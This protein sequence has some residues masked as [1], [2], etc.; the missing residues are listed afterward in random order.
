M[1]HLETLPPNTNRPPLVEHGVRVWLRRT[2]AVCKVRIEGPA[3][4]EW[5]RRHL[6]AGFACSEPQ[7]V[8]GTPYHTF[9][10]ALGISTTFARLQ[11][12]IE[13]LP[14]ATLMLDPA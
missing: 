13:E 3:A 6:P 10:I 5:L 14:G 11:R 7:P 12:T 1:S 9:R 2:G 4:A 8:A